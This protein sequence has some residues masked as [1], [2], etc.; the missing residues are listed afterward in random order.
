MKKIVY[1]IVTNIVKLI[2]SILCRIDKSQ[3]HKV[4]KT[5][6]LIIATNH[7]NFLEAPVIY[8]H[9]Y[10]RKLTGVAKIESWDKPL[11]KLLFTIWDIIPINRG[12]VDNHAFD[13]MQE[14]LK[15]N[16]ILAIAPE[17]TRSKDGK[18]LRGYPGIALLYARIQAPIL[19]VVHYGGEK[20]WE[21]FKKVKRTDFHIVVGNPFMIDFNGEKLSRDV[22]K[23]VVDEVMYQLAALLP[24]EYR[25]YYSDLSKATQTYL[26]FEAASTS[27]LDRVNPEI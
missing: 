26:R 17:G 19:P 21:K 23:Q 8:S 18:L 24:P 12:T 7:I 25:G 11:L 1:H 5:S 4:P 14:A 6:P 3:L 20:F 27:N 22:F 10:P 16:S 9:L 2:F 15:Q 13:L